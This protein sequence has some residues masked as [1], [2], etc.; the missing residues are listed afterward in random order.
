MGQVHGTSSLITLI[1]QSI[2]QETLSFDIWQT[3]DNQFETSFQRRKCL[4]SFEECIS[5]L[6]KMKSSEHNNKNKPI[7]KFM[8]NVLQMNKSEYSLFDLNDNKSLQLKHI[9]SLWTYL[10][11]T[12]ARDDAGRS[13]APQHTLHKYRVSIPSELSMKLNKFIKIILLGLLGKIVLKW[14]N[15]LEAYGN[16]EY[17]IHT[18]T[19][20]QFLFIDDD[21]ELP[22]K[23]KFP[24]ISLQHFATA[25]EYVASKFY[26]MSK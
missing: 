5:F 26:S 24:T 17:N 1:S 19:V 8:Q 21:I 2:Q 12:L 7:Y 13:K 6:S 25:F 9:K 10:T 20:N 14:K 3:F 15:Q 16:V 22:K 18:S 4:D 11:Q 23:V